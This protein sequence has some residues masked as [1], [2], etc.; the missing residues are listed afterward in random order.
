ME[1]SGSVCSLSSGNLGSSGV[2]ISGSTSTSGSGKSGS[3]VDSGLGSGSGVVVRSGS[4]SLTSSPFIAAIRLL[5]LAISF[6]KVTAS[7]TSA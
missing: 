4:G 6:A 7:T 5:R 2:M 3:S 1:S